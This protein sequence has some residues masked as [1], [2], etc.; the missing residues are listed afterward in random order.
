MRSCCSL[1]DILGERSRVQVECQGES[2]GLEVCGGLAAKSVF[3]AASLP[4]H[5]DGSHLSEAA[6]HQANPPLQEVL[7]S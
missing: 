2:E 1:V 3:V 5:V 4:R 6:L 7:T